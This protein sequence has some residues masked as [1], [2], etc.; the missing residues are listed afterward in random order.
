MTF[1]LLFGQKKKKIENVLIEGS[2]LY[3][4]SGFGQHN[5]NGELQI[6]TWTRNIIALQDVNFLYQT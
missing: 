1:S 3:N 4:L 5:A 6:N 2:Y